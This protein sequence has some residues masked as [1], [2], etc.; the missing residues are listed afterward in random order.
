MTDRNHNKL[1]DL[2][3]EKRLRAYA[4]LVKAE[5][6][7]AQAAQMEADAYEILAAMYEGGTK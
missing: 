2:L 7:R 1:V 3:A 4:M 6:M 5:S